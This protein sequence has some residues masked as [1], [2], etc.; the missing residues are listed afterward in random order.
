MATVL[1]FRVPTELRPSALEPNMEEEG[2]PECFMYNDRWGSEGG[3][4]GEGG[5]APLK[6]ARFVLISFPSYTCLINRTHELGGAALA[7]KT[8][9]ATEHKL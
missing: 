9:T 3:G 8:I 5:N 4:G 1:F 7:S 6:K 2:Q